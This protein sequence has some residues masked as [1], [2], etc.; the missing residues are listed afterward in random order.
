[1]L[2]VRLEKAVLAPFAG[3]SQKTGGSKR[4][5]VPARDGAAGRCGNA[6]PAGAWQGSRQGPGGANEGCS[7]F[8]RDN[9]EVLGLH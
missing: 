1:M 5:A 4:G 6:M 9:G 3:V 7:Q 2:L 8:G